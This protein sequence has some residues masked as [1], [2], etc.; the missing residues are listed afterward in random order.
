[1]TKQPAAKDGEAHAG[2]VLMATDVLQL[3]SDGKPDAWK[4]VHE[5]YP[6]LAKKRTRENRKFTA[7]TVLVW[8]TGVVAGDPAKQAM[9]ARVFQELTS[10]AFSKDTT[11]SFKLSALRLLG[12]ECGMFAGKAKAGGK[13]GIRKMQHVFVAPKRIDYEDP[14]PSNSVP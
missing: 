11:P 14:D 9:A 10:I 3:Y 6:E 7:E 8:A 5:K 4:R 2:S 1:M 13:P 12:W